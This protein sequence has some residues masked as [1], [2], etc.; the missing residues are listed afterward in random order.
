MIK[1][2]FQK[3]S[4]FFR[5]IGD[6]KLDS[7]YFQRQHYGQSKKANCSFLHSKVLTCIW[8]QNCTY[9]TACLTRR[10]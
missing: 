9:F 3:F 6:H 8:N 7:I 2:K 5:L 4:V 10:L 1:L